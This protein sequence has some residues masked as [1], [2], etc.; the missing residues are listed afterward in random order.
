MTATPLGLSAYNT[1]DAL[2]SACNAL[3][4]GAVAV[5]GV[6]DNTPATLG[7]AAYEF[8]DIELVM[9]AAITSGSGSPYV[10]AV[11]LR[12]LDGTN[13]DQAGVSNNQIF[14]VTGSVPEPVFP[15]GSISVIYIKRVPLPATLFKIA[16]LN[17]TGVAFAATVTA[18]LYRGE[19]QAG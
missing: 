11:A 1:A 15:S 16:I 9:S 14:P 6:I 5:S 19:Y 2:G 12:C 13:Y 17:E 8:G 3:A 7:H 4:N 10:Q 18:S